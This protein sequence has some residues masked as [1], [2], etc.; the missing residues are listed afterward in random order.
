MAIATRRPRPTLVHQ[1]DR[2]G[3]YRSALYQDALLERGLTQSFSRPGT[4]T[5]NPVCE[6]FIKTLK[7]E[8]IWVRAYVDL[9]DVEKAIGAFVYD[10]N[11]YRSH[12][13]LGKRSPAEFERM[14][15]QAVKSQPAQAELTV[16]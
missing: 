14:H 15:H 2:G 5:D 3:Q 11:E 1:P 16:P 12:S 9:E 13:S 8:E 7:R 10:Y 4:P 6:R